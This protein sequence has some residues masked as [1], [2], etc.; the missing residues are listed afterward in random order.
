VFNGIGLEVGNVKAKFELVMAEKNLVGNTDGVSLSEVSLERLYVCNDLFCLKSCDAHT[1]MGAW[2]EDDASRGMPIDPEF[3]QGF[4]DVGALDGVELGSR[5]RGDG[6]AVAE[7]RE[8]SCGDG[9]IGFNR[10]E[11]S[12]PKAM[13]EGGG[14]LKA[15]SEL[16]F[17]IAR[18][19][20]ADSEDTF[21]FLGRNTFKANVGLVGCN[22]DCPR[23][24]VLR[25]ESGMGKG[26]S[27]PSP[28]HGADY[29]LVQ[30]E[31]SSGQ[32]EEGHPC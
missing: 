28:D 14:L 18:E 2:A 16:V 32:L 30:S 7:G 17:K 3:G 20:E 1:S 5:K 8:E 24:I 13:A 12:C 6:E 9:D 21:S 4:V 15:K 11:G 10:G 27:L 25:G 26:N 22:G 19:W 29:A 23:K 31:I